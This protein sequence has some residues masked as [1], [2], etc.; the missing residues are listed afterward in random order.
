MLMSKIFYMLKG[1]NADFAHQSLSTDPE[2]CYY[3]CKSCVK[4][5]VAQ[6]T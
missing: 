2:E 4:P 6:G 3:I 1:N 5:F